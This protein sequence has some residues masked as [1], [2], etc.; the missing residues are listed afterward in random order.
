[1]NEQPCSLSF[2]YVGCQKNLLP[3][4]KVDLMIS[5]DQDQEMVSHFK[6]YNEHISLTVSRVRFSVRLLEGYG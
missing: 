5:K 1:M 6:R 4:L 2:M 3:R